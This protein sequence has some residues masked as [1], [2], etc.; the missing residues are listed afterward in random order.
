MDWRGTNT[1]AMYRFAVN[2]REIVEMSPH[3]LGGG[4]RYQRMRRAPSMRM[5][6][7]FR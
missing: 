6:S 3:R 7:P 1:S 2:W 4:R 5:T